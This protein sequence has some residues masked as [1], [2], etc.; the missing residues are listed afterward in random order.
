MGFTSYNLDND[1]KFQAAIKRAKTVTDD[2]TI[3]L[4]LISKD[5]YRSE[6]AIFQLQSAGQYPDL[7]GFN[8]SQIRPG[9]KLNNRELAKKKK[10]KK[11]GFIYPILRGSGRLEAS[12]TNAEDK[13]AVNQIVNKRTLIIGTTV[14]YAIYHQSDDPRKKL[15]QR[16]FLFIGPES[17]FANSD[18]QGRVGRWLNILNSFILKKLGEPI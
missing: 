18:Q 11:W 4:T 9:Q 10:Q 6:K 16:K 2:L 12:V 3:P 5:F 7:G 17:S 8:P 13:N 1:G 15:P 14:D